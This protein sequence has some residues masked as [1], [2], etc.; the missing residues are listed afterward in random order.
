MTKT[1]RGGGRPERV[2]EQIRQVLGELQMSGA[3]GVPDL[4]KASLVSFT[5]VKMSPDISVARIYTSVFPPEPEV[6]LAILDALARSARRIR[7]QVGQRMRLRHVP[8]LRFVLDESL[9]RGSRIDALLGEIREASEPGASTG[10]APS[11][12][13]PEEES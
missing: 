7:S 10:P 2:G 6:A 1:G 12:G 9:E 8:E 11:G 5:E 13:D 3:L 4:A